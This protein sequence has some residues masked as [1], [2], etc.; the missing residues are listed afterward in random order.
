MVKSKDLQKVK[1]HRKRLRER[2]LQGGLDGFLDYEIVELLLTLGTPR[3][4]CKPIAKEATKKFSGLRGVLE[5]APEEL[6]QIK[7]L[8]PHN[9][10]GLKFFQALSTHY[11]KEKLPKKITF[12]SPQ[13][14]ANF[15]QEKIGREKKEHFY[16]LALD[17]RNNLI[18]MNNVSTGTL[19][20][21]L[22]HPREVFKE[23][24]QSSAAQVIIAH[25]HPSGDP[26]PSEGDLVITNRLV[27]AGKILEIAVVDHIIVTN[28]DFLSLKERKLL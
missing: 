9:I 15:L 16:I 4:D 27:E 8:G 12:D 19:D 25:N 1:G 2:F 21:S 6:R 10:F 26:E 23:A 13:V 22:V 3:K 7:G 18:K 17:S 28:N 5:A 24:I 20:A 14:V 11:A